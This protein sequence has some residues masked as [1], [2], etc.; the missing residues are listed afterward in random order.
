LLDASSFSCAWKGVVVDSCSILYPILYRISQT[1]MQDDCSGQVRY[2]PVISRSTFPRTLRTATSSQIAICR[3][4]PTSSRQRRRFDQLNQLQLFTSLVCLDAVQLYYRLYRFNRSISSSLPAFP[5]R[6]LEL[7][8][9]K[10]IQ[11]RLLISVALSFGSPEPLF[12]RENAWPSLIFHDG[13][14]QRW[15]GRDTYRIRDPG[16]SPSFLRAVTR[17]ARTVG[18]SAREAGC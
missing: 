8:W 2:R 6:R 4:S 1:E 7:E 16:R 10:G 18:R 13:R 3:A 5:S 17:L 11:R 15:K 12:D 9:Q 14:A